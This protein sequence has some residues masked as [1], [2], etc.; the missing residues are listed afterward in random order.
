[1]DLQFKNM[2]NIDLMNLQH[3]QEYISHFLLF[4]HIYVLLFYMY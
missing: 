2:M 4:Y 1:M 3:M